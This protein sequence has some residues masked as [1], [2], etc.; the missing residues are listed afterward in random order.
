MAFVGRK[1]LKSVRARSRRIDAIFQYFAYALLVSYFV[2]T[3]SAWLSYRQALRIDSVEIVGARAVDAG[4]ISEIVNVALNEKILWK[5]DRNNAL[6]YPKNQIVKNIYLLSGRVKSVSTEVVSKKHLIVTVNE[7]EPKLLACPNM[8]TTS[9]SNAACYFAD[10]T[11]YVFARSPDYSGYFF[12]IFVTH[13]ASVTDENIIGTHV[14]PG[15]EFL[16]A[17]SFLS[18]LRNEGYTTRR[19][20]Y[21]GGHDYEVFTDRPWS[22]LWSSTK[23]PEVTVNNLKLL[24]SSIVQQ[25]TENID[26][27]SVIDLRFGNKIF[28]H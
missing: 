8:A 14:L 23:N 17:Q 1:T 24:L 22:I 4:K 12:P 21:L 16:I 28:Y 26:E 27:L 11:G 10:E 18:A 9:T 19:I 6:L 25:K 13:D 5:I 7:F 2:F 3:I 20:D 15:D